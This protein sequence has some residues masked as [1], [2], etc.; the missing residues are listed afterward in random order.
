MET[1]GSDVTSDPQGVGEAQR[2]DS[3]SGLFLQRLGVLL[4]AGSH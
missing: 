2:Q 4:T 3:N 1:W